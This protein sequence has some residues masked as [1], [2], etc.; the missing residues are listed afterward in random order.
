MEW[1]PLDTQQCNMNFSEGEKVNENSVRGKR[2]GNKR[3]DKHSRLLFAACRVSSAWVTS[4]KTQAVLTLAG[5]LPS[6]ML[7]LEK[8]TRGEQSGVK[9]GLQ[10]NLQHVT[11]INTFW[12][13]PPLSSTEGQLDTR[14]LKGKTQD[15]NTPACTRKQT[16]PFIYFFISSDGMLQPPALLSS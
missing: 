5:S 13:S 3:T 10:I 12:I 2:N 9:A 1:N 15:K 7:P 6:Q 8:R 16:V 14:L 4:L 11:S